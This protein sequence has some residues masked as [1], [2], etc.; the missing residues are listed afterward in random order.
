MMWNEIYGNLHS[1]F[2]T[3]RLSWRMFIFPLTQSRDCQVVS[4]SLSDVQVGVP[5]SRPSRRL[6]WLESLD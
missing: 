6:E 3:Y 5:F 1:H 4:F 2:N